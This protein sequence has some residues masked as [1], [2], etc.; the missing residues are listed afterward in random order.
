MSADALRVAREKAAGL[1]P[2]AAASRIGA[3]WSEGDHSLTLPFLGKTASITHPAYEV[4]VA[5]RP[6][7][8][9]IA[10]LLVYHL[11]LS[12]GS[13]PIGTWV[14]FADLP[15]ASFYVTAFRGYTGTR[16]AR[17]FASHVTRLDSAIM[18]VGSEKLPGLADHAWLVPAL[19]RVPMALLWWEADDEFEARA[20]IL[21]DSTAS[22]HLTTDGC[23]ILGSW[24]TSMLIRHEGS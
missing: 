16:I 19:P 10:A 8:P 14:S 2:S 18:S 20:E 6:A 17:H 3:E 15:D 23:A 9:H 11:V 1:D 12:D 22:H 7:P 24:L 13:M 21:F 5:A 4:T